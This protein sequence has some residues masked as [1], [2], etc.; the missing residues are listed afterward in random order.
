MESNKIV[1]ILI[2]GAVLSFL[3][4]ISS[5]LFETVEQGTYQ[6]KQA[7]LSGSMSA[8]MDPGIWL[9]MF[10]DISVWTKAETFY[11]TSDK[12][13]GADRDQSVEVTFVDGSK[14]N[15]SGSMRILMPASEQQAIELITKHGFR[16][17]NEVEQRLILP[18][19]QKALT[20][21][22]NMMTATESYSDKRGDFVAWSEDQIQ[23]GIYEAESVIKEYVDPTTKE[24]TAK[25]FRVV[26]L[27][28][29]G[30]KIYQPSQLH[31]TGI[32]VSNFV[33]K[34]IIYS[35]TV[36]KQIESQQKAYMEVATGKA[37][38]LKAE[39]NKLKQIAEG[40][41]AV[42]KAQYEKETIKAQEITMA[43]QRLEVAELDKQA[44]S[45]KKQKDI[46]EGEGEAEKRKLIMNADGALAQK[47]AAWVEVNKAYASEVGKQRWVP[48]IQMGNAGGGNAAQDLINLLTTK[49]AKDLALDF[50]QPKK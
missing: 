28:S 9:Q 35:E 44:A 43:K 38:V 34:K 42:A 21:T 1:K 3:L 12:D 23:N 40:Q 32:L 14:A 39:Q 27:D 2:L 13:E 20:L 17:M 31:G 36:E 6:I 37:E 7:A 45:L 33:V 26:K 15:I 18:M 30:K 5:K 19:V 4:S 41:A 8:K 29:E 48:E 16:T 49:T 24:K 10:G 11:F 50:G 47:L 25:P 22:A 46:L